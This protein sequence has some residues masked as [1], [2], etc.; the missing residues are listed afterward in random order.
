MPLPKLYTKPTS[1]SG[2]KLPQP[3]LTIKA[4]SSN[5][6]GI[7]AVDENGEWLAD[8]ATVG[9][10]LS[11]CNASAKSTISNNGYDTSW[12]EWD[13]DGCFVKLT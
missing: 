10:N 9:D 4:A 3:L 6:L 2:K 1:N 13:K 7:L 5:C 8:I 11:Q 12:A